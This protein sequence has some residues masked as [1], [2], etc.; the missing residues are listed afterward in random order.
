[1]YGSAF[2]FSAC[3]ALGALAF[4][5]AGCGGANTAPASVPSAALPDAAAH[6]FDAIAATDRDRFEIL[7]GFGEKPANGLSPTGSLVEFD[8]ALVGATFSGGLQECNGLNGCGTV[9]AIAP[10]RAERVIYRFLGVP[11]GAAPVG[12]FLNEN[13]VLYG[14]TVFGGFGR[15][16]LSLGCGTVF[17][18][19]STGR[20][21]VLYAFKGGEDG[22]YPNGGVVDVGG[23]LY[24][25]TAS[26]GTANNGTVFKIEPTGSAVVLHSFKAP[27]DG[28]APAA[29]LTDEGGTLY[30]TTE[31]GGKFGFGTVFAITPAGAEHVVYS[32]KGGADGARPQATLVASN[33]ALFGTTAAGG[34]SRAC[35]GG[36]GTVFEVMSSGAEKVLHSFAGGAD[37]EDSLAGLVA[38]DGTLFGT[39][40]GGSAG[41]GAKAYGTIF[42]I[43]RS[44]RERVL[45]RFSGK[46]DGG[47][48]EAGLTIRG[49]TLFGAATFGGPSGGGTVFS[50]QSAHG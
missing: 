33:G 2:R 25:T 27:P 14:V 8:G 47:R 34:G 11:D 38:F 36:C 32:F 41:G 22:A 20:E 21:T 3:A 1:L 9:F 18:L 13:G 43:A 39:T 7:H 37:G 19:T 26:G 16:C 31:Q 40:F 29:G 5:L 10:S 35:S 4:V 42:S 23:T 45:H 30:G 46:I 50:L 49:G 17:G 48:P 6:A 28:L 24:G 44:G 15:G 12:P